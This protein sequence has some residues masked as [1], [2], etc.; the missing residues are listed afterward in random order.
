MSLRGEG[1]FSGEGKEEGRGWGLP[2]KLSGWGKE[3]GENGRARE[4]RGRGRTEDRKGDDAAV[5]GRARPERDLEET[6]E[7]RFASCQRPGRGEVWGERTPTP[8]R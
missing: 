3:R 8:S 2:K 4:G 1:G 7:G 6:L 5:G